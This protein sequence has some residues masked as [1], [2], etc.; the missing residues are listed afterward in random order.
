MGLVRY[1]EEPELRGPVMVI[2]LRGWPDGGRVS[3]GSV[4]YLISK[5]SAKRFA[6]IDSSGFYDLTLKRPYVKC[7]KGVIM[8]YQLPDNTFHYVGDVLDGGLILFLGEEPSF[9]WFEYVDALLEVIRRFSVS[10]VFTVGGLLDRIP[11]TVEPVV[12][13]STNSAEEAARLS[14]LEMDATDYEGPSSVHSLILYRLKQER[15]VAL[16]LWGHSP[17]YLSGMDLQT[18]YHVVKRLSELIG[19]EVD[20]ND[21]KLECDAFRERLDSEVKSNEELR[22]V[23]AELENEYYLS[24]RRPYYVS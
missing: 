12:T 7:R 22:N 17:Y 9:R 19:L 10:R 4:S 18:I 5:L 21:L 13:F 2:G 11:H 23:V 1:F 16:S 8:E 15:I 14:R 20:L 24:R 6:E 3:S